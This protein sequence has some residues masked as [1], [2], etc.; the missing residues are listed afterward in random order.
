MNSTRL[1][2]PWDPD[3]D[4]R[5]LSRRAG[6]SLGGTRLTSIFPRCLVLCAV[7]L[8]T[9]G[10]ISAQSFSPTWAAAKP[11]VDKWDAEYKAGNRT[12]VVRDHVMAEIKD[13]LAQ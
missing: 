3:S 10:A 13:L 4:P 2:G 12:T 8:I 6:F 9:V 1:K 11:L 5:D 7:A